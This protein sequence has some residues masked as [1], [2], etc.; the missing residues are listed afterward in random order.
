MLA[1][2][3]PSAPT[4]LLEVGGRRLREPPVPLREVLGLAGR[5]L[6]VTVEPLGI[7][8]LVARFS[9]PGTI[10]IPLTILALMGLSF[11]ALLPRRMKWQIA[12]LFGLMVVQFLLAVLGASGSSTAAAVRGLHG[13]NAVVIVGLTVW[14][15]YR[16]WALRATQSA[17]MRRRCQPLAGPTIVGGA[18]T[19]CNPIAFHSAVAAP[20]ELF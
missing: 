5:C 13:L 12:V 1:G 16:N 18:L 9:R 3:E 4:R 19:R 6:V 7:Q 2:L 17:S 11:G 20:E 14:L 15:V 10:V 8:I